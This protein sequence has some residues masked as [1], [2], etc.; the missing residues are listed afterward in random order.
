MA[1]LR[2][3]DRVRTHPKIVE[4]GPAAAWLWFCGICYCREHLIDGVIP[5]SVL[6]LLAPGLPNP[7][8]HA[9]MLVSVG[10]WH[11]RE[12]GFEIH[13]F[14]DWN[15]SRQD[16]E[17][18]KE[19]DRRRK[20]LYADPTL[21]GAIRKRDGDD[22][23]Y[24]GQQVNWKD[25]R[26]PSGG[27][28]DYVIPRGDNS[29]ENIVVACRGCNSTK[30]GR[31]PEQAG[32]VLL[33]P[34]NQPGFSSGLGSGISS[35]LSSPLR[36][37]AGAAGLG[38]GSDSSGS[39]VSF[40]EES[41]RET[42]PDDGRA[43]WFWSHWRRL[44]YA[45]SGVDLPLTPTPVELSNVSKAIAR[46]ADDATLV[47]AV[48]KFMELSDEQSKQLN[49]KAKTVGFFVMALPRLLQREAAFGTTARTAGN[50]AAISAFVNQGGKS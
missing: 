1:W 10:L 6:P 26:G 11:Q 50:A 20:E 35:G 48:A 46:V 16:V 22:C 34:K 14:L 33:P 27:N 42:K 12:T 28:Y 32:M 5:M 43:D 19:W 49:V 40:S 45:S 7:K 39:G 23:R 44:M 36:A 2:V 24:C 30:G 13:D 8:R 21:I 31:T 18:S 38:L 37:H 4:A 25:R 9:A 47:G 3:D 29:L 15:P 17:A 41:A